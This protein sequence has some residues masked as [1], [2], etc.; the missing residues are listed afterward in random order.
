[1]DTLRCLINEQFTHKN[2]LSLEGEEDG[3]GGMKGGF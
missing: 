3:E 1:V 2:E